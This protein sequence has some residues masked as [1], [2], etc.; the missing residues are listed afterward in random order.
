MRY[1]IDV[2]QRIMIWPHGRFNLQNGA[3]FWQRAY[4]STGPN[5]I[6]ALR[7]G[8]RELGPLHTLGGGGGIR[9][10]LGKAGAQED[11]VLSTAL[12]GYWTSFADAVYVTERF[13]GLTATTLDIAF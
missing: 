11:I 9:F 10:A 7:T 5:D 2:S 8:D 6:P 12:D 1:F 4:G 3:D 13:S